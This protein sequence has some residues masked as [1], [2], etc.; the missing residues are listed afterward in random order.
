MMIWKM[1]SVQLRIFCLW[2]FC[3]LTG[4]RRMSCCFLS[5]TS[6]KSKPM[7][8]RF[9]SVRS[10]SLGKLLTW[11]KESSGVTGITD[12]GQFRLLLYSDSIARISITKEDAFDDF[13]YAVV[14]E[15]KPIAFE[16]LE[17]PSDLWIITS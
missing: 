1:R 5:F 2:T 7:S 9:K 11:K 13:S 4:L 17:S 10:Q 8:H 6:T 12:N 15:A 14:A 3:F 16:V